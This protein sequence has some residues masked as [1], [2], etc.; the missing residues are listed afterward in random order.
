MNLVTITSVIRPQNA[1]S[2]FSERERFEQLLKSIQSAKS[3]VPNCYIAVLEGSVCTQDEI[4]EMLQSGA[5]HVLH[6]DIIHLDKQFGECWLLKTFFT[7]DIFSQLHHQHNFLT[8]NKLS[9]RYFFK[10]EFTFHYDGETCICKMTEPGV[11]YSTHGWL[12]TRYFSIPTKYLPNFLRGLD[13]CIR[14]MFINVEHSFY[15]YNVIPLDKINLDVQTINVAGYIA[16]T[17][18]YLDE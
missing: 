11:S 8:I 7:S 18:D 4:R 3:K 9:G 1:P 12:C 17:G 14:S 16:T 6:V 2:V 15:R 13:D 10:D 5:D